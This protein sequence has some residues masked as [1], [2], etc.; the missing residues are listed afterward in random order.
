LNRT[1]TFLAIDDFD[2]TTIVGVRLPG[3]EIKLNDNNTES[4]GEINSAPGDLM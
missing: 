1:E 4:G 2:F 3:G